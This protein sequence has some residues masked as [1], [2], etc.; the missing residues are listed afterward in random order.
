MNE[1]KLNPG[2]LW[3]EAVSQ[4]RKALT[5]GALQPIVTRPVAIR[6]QGIDFTIHTLTAVNAKKVALAEQRRTTAS[7]HFFDPFLPPYEPD[8]FVA[9]LS[10]T[11]V[12][13]LNKYPV[14]AHHLLVVTRHWEAQEDLLT[15]ADFRAL[16][17]C[18]AQVDGLAFFNG[19]RVAGAS[20]PHKHLQ[21]VPFAGNRGVAPLTALIL[22]PGGLPFPHALVRLDSRLAQDPQAAARQSFGH[23]H[24]MLRQVGLGRHLGRRLGECAQPGPYNLLLTR[25]W[26]LLVPR[27][28]EASAG[29]G[30][31]GMGF[32]GSLLARDDVQM[33]YLRQRTPLRFLGDLV[34]RSV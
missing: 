21:L 22:R 11:H 6:Q 16:W 31:N 2:T 10:P 12:C 33:A 30:V 19:G 26:M 18:M 3:P 14:L 20:Q 29:I 32:A 15:W 4:S 23:Y 8:L 25:E 24:R 1:F 27:R 9:D 5:S 28:L 34:G 17:A 13:V 7:G